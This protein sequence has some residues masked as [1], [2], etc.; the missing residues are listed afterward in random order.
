MSKKHRFVVVGK[1]RFPFDMLR[2]DRAYPVTTTAAMFLDQADED[3]PRYIE[4]ESPESPSDP[5]WLSFGWT[6]VAP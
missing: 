5:R 4:L 3:H 1:G 2:Y 6:V